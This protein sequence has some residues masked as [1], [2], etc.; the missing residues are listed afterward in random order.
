MLLDRDVM[1]RS[2]MDLS[3]RASGFSVFLTGTG[4]ESAASTGSDLHELEHGTLTLVFAGTLA[5][6]KTLIIDGEDFTALNDGTNA[7]K[8]LTGDFPEIFAGPNEV[9]YTDSESTR[10]VKVIVTKSDRSL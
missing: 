6:G 10:S 4:S 7:I 2:P 8:D 3:W 9:I 1:D 5:A